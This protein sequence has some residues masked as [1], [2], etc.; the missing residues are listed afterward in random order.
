MEYPTSIFRAMNCKSEAHWKALEVNKVM[1]QVGTPAFI[2]VQ[3]P[4]P[5]SK[6]K[7]QRRRLVDPDFVMLLRKQFLN[8]EH[9]TRRNVGVSLGCTESIMQFFA[10]SAKW[11]V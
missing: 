9:D 1:D 4:D 2:A 11:T 3:F 5:W 10:A 6:T 8:D 7:H